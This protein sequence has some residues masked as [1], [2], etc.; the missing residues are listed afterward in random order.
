M[1]N[2][3]QN[4]NNQII[5]EY[6]SGES[7]NKLSKKYNKNISSIMYLLRKSNVP[8]RSIGD[9]VIK[10]KYDKN[11]IIFTS[12]FKE[13]LTGSLMGDGSLRIHKK[14]RNPYYT[15]TDKNR[16]AILY[17]KQI[18]EKEGI[19]T[20]KIWI[21]KH[22]K[23]YCFQTEA[24]KGFLE[25]YNLF[26]PNTSKKELPNINLTPT[27]LLFWYMGDGSIKKQKGTL[28][29]ACQISNKF[30]NSFILNQLKSLFNNNSNYYKEKNRQVGLFYIPHKGFIKLI[31]YIGECPIECY[32]YK[33]IIRRCSETIIEES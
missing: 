4:F 26:Y 28:N 30:G 13:F 29:N 16:E 32:K 1:G 14:G 19:K 20:S 23:C 11:K 18:F 33:W 25:F 5:N 31:D 17:F 21:N 6:L 24:R 15:H 8:I 7:A 22:S 9:N 2:Q 3:Q 12:F 10:S 27:I